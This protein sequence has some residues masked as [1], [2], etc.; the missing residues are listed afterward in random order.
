MRKK[1]LLIWVFFF[2]TQA[3]PMICFC[4]S[5]NDED[6]LIKY[7]YF[8]ELDNTGGPIL[9]FNG[10]TATGFYFIN[11]GITQFFSVGH[12]L[13]GCDYWGGKPI[14]Y[15][16]CMMVH[17]NDENGTVIAGKSLLHVD[18]RKL[19]FDT[20]CYANYKHPDIRSVEVVDTNKVF[21]IEKIVNL[22][23]PPNPGD[24]IFYGFPYYENIKDRRFKEKKPLKIKSR[25]FQLDANFLTNDKDGKMIMDTLNYKIQLDDVVINDTFQ[26]FLGSPIF[27][28]DLAT[29]KWHFLGV[30]VAAEA[31]MKYII[32]VK[33]K[34]VEQ[35]WFN[36]TMH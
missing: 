36:S 29:R 27:C 10:A 2:C 30:L 13:N 23:L 26:G 18:L 25:I 19:M 5:Q 11:N 7:S 6:S 3:T 14:A 20:V 12:V 24:I 8:I 16:H 15:P 4:Q 35:F 21:S 22:G 9:F 33:S 32:V 17:R 28:Q 1:A 34:Y 31:A